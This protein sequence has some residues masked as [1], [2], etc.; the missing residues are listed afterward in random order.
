MDKDKELQDAVNNAAKTF[1]MQEEEEVAAESKEQEE[2]AE[3]Q[4]DRPDFSYL[5]L[6]SDFLIPLLKLLQTPL[7]L[8]LT[9]TILMMILLFRMLKNL[10]MKL[11]FCR[12][13]KMQP[14]SSKHGV[15]FTIS[16]GFQGKME[17]TKGGMNTKSPPVIKN[18]PGLANLPET[19]V[20]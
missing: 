2:A 13:M 4:S 15:Q 8:L 6:T 10:V 16:S 12:K 20:H 7:F 9:C 1:T 14:F 11:Q 3:E 18:G 17:C 5:D 19:D